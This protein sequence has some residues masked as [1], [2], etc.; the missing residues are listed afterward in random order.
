MNIENH[1]VMQDHARNVVS[2]L[3]PLRPMGNSRK[4]DSWSWAVSFSLLIGYLSAI[5]LY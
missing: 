4:A 3:L 5:I 2:E 1:Y